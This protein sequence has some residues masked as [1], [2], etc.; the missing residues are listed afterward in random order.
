MCCGTCKGARHVRRDA[1][2]GVPG[3]DAVV[4]LSFLKL[5]TDTHGLSDSGGEA[6]PAGS[7]EVPGPAGEASAPAE[8]GAD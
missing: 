6:G 8:C 3:P 4:K 2:A 1:P 5:L 7:G